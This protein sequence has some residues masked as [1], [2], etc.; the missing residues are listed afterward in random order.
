MD[1]KDKVIVGTGGT[2]ILGYRFNKAIS[3]AGA[4]VCILGR[5]R[6][7]AIERAAEIIAG[8]VKA[9]GL[10]ANVLNETDLQNAHDLILAKFRKIDGL[11]NA[12]VGN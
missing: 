9:I 8:G 3:K 6:E 10:S 7:K 1:L 11:V 2:G 12:V 5:N 4:I